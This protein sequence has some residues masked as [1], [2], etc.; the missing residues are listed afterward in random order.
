MSNS[1]TPPGRK[2]SGSGS[3]VSAAGTAGQRVRRS[4]VMNEAAKGPQARGAQGTAAEASIARRPRG[5]VVIETGA[6][7]GRKS[8]AGAKVRH[9][10]VDTNVLLHDP[11]ALFV[12]QEHEVIIPLVVIEELDRFKRDEGDRG[13]NAR[14]CIR[15]LDRLR[16]MGRLAD[17]VRWGEAA[18]T[19]GQDKPITALPP[20]ADKTGVI[21]IEVGEFPR[22]PMIKEDKADN[23]IIACALGTA[24]RLK[25]TGE[26]VVFVTKDLNARIKAD[27][28]GLATEDFENKK[29]DAQRLYTGSMTIDVDGDLIDE[30]YRD[31]LLPLD[32]IEAQLRYTGEDGLTR[33]RT[34]Y[35]NQF[36]QLRDTDD[37]NHTGLARRLADTD[38]L[39]PVTGPRK[40]T[41]GI[42]P[43]NLQQTMALD[44]LMDEEVRMVTLLGSAG[45]GKTL[46][47]V[48]AG[49]AKVFNEERYDKMLV[50]RPI[51]PMGRDIGYLPGTKD[52]KL[53]AWMQPIFDNIGYLLSTRS[54]PMQHAESQTTEQRITKL[55]DSGKLVLEPLTYIRG[56]S[57]PHQF[58]IV[59]EAQ[60]LTPHEVKTIASRIGEGTKLVLTGD[61]GQIDNPYLDQASNGLSYAIERMKGLRIVGHVTMTK[62]ERSELASLAASLL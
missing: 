14:E 60:N 18:E 45:T 39:I 55:V 58:M 8:G 41:F 42:L 35:A 50:A 62:S 48:A 52:E 4:D 31:R 47:A 23:H 3:G 32:R 29:V 28:L 38:H 57:I 30:L 16:K 25:G 49:M 17:G 2:G 12:F 6:K 40:P 22:P 13:R 27:A 61:I 26:E 19:N 51:M 54:G 46:M 1:N 56:R 7:S 21:R 37:E 33:R 53:G 15:H 10:V 24:E 44:L 59:D 9:F 5:D 11:T 36:V 34:V 20:S 43:R